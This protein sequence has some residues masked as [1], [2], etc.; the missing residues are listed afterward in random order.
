MRASATPTARW[1][2]TAAGLRPSSSPTPSPARST[3]TTTTAGTGPSAPAASPAGPS[4]AAAAAGG[5]GPAAPP[6]LLP[7]TAPRG[8]APDG[9]CGD[10]DGGVWGCV[11]GPG[12]IA[13]HLDGRVDQVVEAG[14]ALPSDVTFGGPDL[15]R[16][17]F[18]SIGGGG[19]GP[20]GGLFAVDGLGVGGRREPRF[21]L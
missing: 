1:C 20:G 10:A 15:D 7:E 2:S 13:R 14:V 18:V 4:T 12:V 19:D 16:M 5:A 21:R 8:G 17:F 9:A 11:L 6:R 3:P